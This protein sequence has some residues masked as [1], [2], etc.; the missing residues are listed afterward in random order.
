MP[1]PDVLQQLD[2]ELT[3]AHSSTVLAPLQSLFS[4]VQNSFLTHMHAWKAGYALQSEREHVVTMLHKFGPFRTCLYEDS[5]QLLGNII[6]ICAC[7]SEGSA[8]QEAVIMK[9]LYEPEMNRL[10]P[11]SN[12]F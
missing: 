11:F 1:E 6:W 10:L 7:R 5:H 2:T 12:E 9:P 3:T 4:L 8:E